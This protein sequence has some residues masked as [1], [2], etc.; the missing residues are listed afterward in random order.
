MKKKSVRSLLLGVM[1]LAVAI[2]LCGCGGDKQTDDAGNNSQEQVAGDETP[3]GEPTQGGSVTVGKTQDLA[4]LDPHATSDAGTRDVVFNL[5]EGL[6]KVT[7]A[8][9]LA[10]AVASDYVISEDAKT[11]TFT[12]REGITF[13]DGSAVTVNDIKYSL[14]RY[15]EAQ[16]ST[17]FFDVVEEVAIVD[18]K[19]VEIYLSEGNSELLPE[20]T[21]AIIPEANEDVTGNPIGTGPFKFVSYTPGQNIVMERY[22]GYWGDKAYLDQV[23]FKFIADVETAFMELQAKTI[24]VLNYLTADQVAML[25]QD[26]Y[27]IIN[28]SMH[29][30]HAMFLNNAYEPLSDV[31]VRQALCHAVDRQSINDF[32]FGGASELIGTHMI[33]SLEVY[34][35]DET[36]NLYDYNPQKAKDLLAEA[37]YADGFD[38][39][40]TVPSSYTQHVNTGEII[41]ENLKAVGINASLELIE[42]SSWVSDVYQGRQYQATVCGFDGDL[43]PSDW[44]AKYETGAGKNFFNYSSEDFDRVY[45]EAYATVDQA[46][47]AELYKELQMILAKDAVNVFIEDPAD[48][49]ATS[50]RIAGYRVYPVA[51]QDMSTVYC[52]EQ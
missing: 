7:A 20:L 50:D 48:F 1:V 52:V 34:Y 14:E 22:D 11:Y 41:V 3:A 47:K 26:E 5:F 32:L 4:S 44:V 8:G 28:G 29:L 15:M 30:V 17:S 6:V 35:N 16:T 38:L 39:K 19:T 45:R 31:R 9:D 13:H 18:D 46:K 43:N 27:T 23:T 42:W 37:G 36:T 25:N 51:G 24:D 21:M 33:P 2:A 40:I 12:L 10:P 49:V